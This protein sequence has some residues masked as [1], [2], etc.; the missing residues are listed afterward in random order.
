[1]ERPK[2]WVCLGDS[3]TEGLGERRAT[4]VSEL[5]KLLR[6]SSGGSL[7]VHDARLRE[8]DPATFNP[9]VRTNLAGHLDADPADASRVL[10]IWN[11]ASEGQTIAADRRWMPLLRNLAPERIL[12]YRGSLESIIRPACV[13][14]GAWPWWVP[15]SWRGLVSMD[16]RVYFS[17]TW[18]RHAK[19]AGID[20]MKQRVRHKLL[21]QR[22]GRPL[23]DAEVL[24]GHYSALLHSLSGLGARVH[25][26]GLIAPEE[27]Q[28]PGSGA[29]FAELNGRL[30][31]L[32]ASSGADFIDW[33]PAVAARA[34]QLPWRYR[35][36]F[37]PH[38][39]GSQLL[40]GILHDH[41]SGGAR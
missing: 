38:L 29:H 15:R 24:L 40:A 37:H 21:A 39:T 8:V 33:A 25:M 12:I 36:G 31:S 35:D 20:A 10:W 23:F 13:R 6:A 7:V 11:L 30:G 18:Y 27:S 3:L 19:Q 34:G 17:T 2:N 1:V 4:Y 16:P 32:A 28:F 5:V 22:P 26:L 14:D 9:Y 41:I